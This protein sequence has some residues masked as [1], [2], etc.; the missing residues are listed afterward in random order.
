MSNLTRNCKEDHLKEITHHR[1][2]ENFVAYLDPEYVN[3]GAETVLSRVFQAFEQGRYE[4]PNTN[5]LPHMMV[6]L[7]E[8]LDSIGKLIL[9][10]ALGA[11][12]TTL[13]EAG[14]LC[15]SGNL[16]S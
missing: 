11:D 6:Q 4:P 1:T 5:S 14:F 8:K 10:K 13:R 9:L 16:W 3:T 2:S 12:T 15:S 7:G